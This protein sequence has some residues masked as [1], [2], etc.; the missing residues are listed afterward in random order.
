LAQT[1]TEELQE[2]KEAILDGIAGETVQNMDLSLSIGYQL[3]TDPDQSLAD[4]YKD[5]ENIM[6]KYKLASGASVRNHAIQAIYKTLTDK[7]EL[8]RNHSHRVS[9]L[10]VALG[11]ALGM[12]ADEL[13]E[14]ELSGLFHD[15]G[16]IS[17]PDSILNKPSRLTKEEYD[18]VKSHTRNGYAILRAADEYSDLAKNALYHHEHYDGGGYPDGLK[19]DAI[20]IQSRIIHIADAFEAMT[21]DR[22]YRKA[23]PVERA[24]AELKKYQGTQFDPN[25]LDVFLEHVLP[26]LSEVEGA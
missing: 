8:E 6:Y 1:S 23:M 13:N 20:P 10:S 26:A 3:K 21:S 11:K 17:L 9:E 2:L 7:Y 14:L 15:I 12:H 19:G 25:L 18:I 4:L 16:K 24:I 5:A 22:P